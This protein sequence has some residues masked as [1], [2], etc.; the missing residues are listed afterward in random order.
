M[1]CPRCG[2]GK[3]IPIIYGMPGRELMEEA[4]AGTVR[5]GGCCIIGDVPSDQF[6][7]SCR[8]AW[9]DINDAG[10]RDGI[11][12]MSEMDRMM[13]AEATDNPGATG[14]DAA[15]TLPDGGR[16][17]RRELAAQGPLFPLYIIDEM[18]AVRVVHAF[19]EFI[20][21]TPASLADTIIVDL[22]AHRY[23]VQEPFT[24]TMIEDEQ[25]MTQ[26]ELFRIIEIHRVRRHMPDAIMQPAF[27]TFADLLKVLVTIAGSDQ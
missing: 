3:V 10:T 1:P 26:V 22:L 5:L 14:A 21:F 17:L 24:V 4:R 15:P 11:K 9:Y 8:F 16:R 7:K 19:A 13:A 27:V 12:A 18:A 2:S 6:C 20:G 23:R 25:P